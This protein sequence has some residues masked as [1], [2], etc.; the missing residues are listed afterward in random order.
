VPAEYFCQGGVAR[1]LIRQ[2]M[3]GWLPDQIR[4]ERRR[5]L[6]AADFR[7]HFQTERQEA[8]AELARMK[9]IDLAARALDLEGLDQMMQWPEARIAVYGES[10]Y[11]AKLMRALSLGRFL[12]RAEEG[13]FF[14][15]L[16]QASCLTETTV[17]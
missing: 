1:T 10:A 2:A 5:G 14:T 4:L 3:E 12:R 15:A 8:L 11:W 13:T 6:Q 16:P 9:R 7:Y 17:V